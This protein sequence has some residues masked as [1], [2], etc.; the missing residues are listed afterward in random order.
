MKAPVVSNVDATP[1]NETANVV[2]LLYRQMFSPVRWESCVR[3]MAQ[4]GVE[5]FVEVGPQKVLANLV[6][7][8]TPEIPCLHV[9]EMEEVEAFK[10]SMA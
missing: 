1:N 10:R 3:R 4:E 2:D 7:R 9:E 6:K 8:I 5:L